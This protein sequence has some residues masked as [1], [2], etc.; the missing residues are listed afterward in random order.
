MFA[1]G[2][3]QE[4][5]DFFKTTQERKAQLAFCCRLNGYNG[6]VAAF[7]ARYEAEAQA[8][9]RVVTGSIPNPNPGHLASY[10][11]MMGTAFQAQESFIAN[12]LAKW[13]PRL[14][15]GQR[16]NLA[17]ALHQALEEQA[18]AGK[19]EPILKNLYTKLM[20]WLYYDFARMLHLL[21]KDRLPKVLYEGTPGIHELLLLH[22][23]AR[24]GCDVLLV[25]PEGD[26]AYLKQ[27]PQSQK[28]QAYTAPDLEPF[29]AGFSLQMIREERQKTETLHSLSGPAPDV[30]VSVNT[31]PSS[32]WLE[33][34]KSAPSGRGPETDQTLYTC[35]VR[36]RGVE[37]RASYVGELYQL[38]L[39]L[40]AADRK[41]L[42][43]EGP[44]PPPDNA[45]I[46]AI[47]RGQNRETEGIIRDMLANLDG[48]GDAQVQ[49][50]LRH[51]LVNLLLEQAEEPG[52]TPQRLASRAVSAL[53]RLK[54][55]GKALF[56]GRKPGAIACCILLGA[57]ASKAD[58]LF[59]RLLARLPV[60]LLIL[61]PT[62]A[63]NDPL[64]DPLLKDLCFPETL[65]LDRYPRESAE[66]AMGTAAYQAERDLD[67]LM[68]ADGSLFRNR[69]CE[70]AVALTLKTTYEE[71]A[72]LWEQEAKYRPNFAAVG[73]TAHIP[74]LYAKVSGVRNADVSAYW[75][76]LRHLL[77]PETLL[78]T[79]TPFCPQVQPCPADFLQG[80]KLRRERIRAHSSYGYGVLREEVQEHILEKIQALLDQELIRDLWQQDRERVVLNSLLQLDRQVTRLLQS[81]DFT[82]KTPKAV[83][84]NTGETALSLEDTALFAFLNLAGFDVLFFVPTGYRCVEQH[85]A[86]PGFEEHQIG[87]YLYDLPIPNFRRPQSATGK[88]RSW[89]DFFKF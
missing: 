29:P 19:S 60:D 79:K 7:L 69:Q 9:G 23:L 13:L 53:C 25:Q 24:V 70:R 44:P 37:D 58:A 20:C 16:R 55:Y 39:A 46:N 36:I 63:E 4:L 71:I 21:G 31:Q 74:V 75:E 56:E 33:A 45:E 42:I 88:G 84:V 8:R 57:C 28:S 86:K 34:V 1:L 85:F 22:H 67:S 5:D 87:D 72:L 61:Q 73:D 64:Q 52:M 35:F 82:K 18:R 76:A 14:E 30:R 80:R 89:R 3:I 40:E 68:Y 47:H 38:P 43:L 10:T 83:Y 32:R 66:L 2:T 15:E 26:A 78:I 48:L 27:D 77:T 49:A 11:E 41:T 51:A 81:F 6:R 12:S 59:L 62:P 54:R 50:L 65:A 17:A